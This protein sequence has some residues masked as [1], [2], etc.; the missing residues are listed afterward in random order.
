MRA[1]QHLKSQPVSP[2]TE[3]PASPPTEELCRLVPLCAADLVLLTT[4]QRRPWVGPPTEE[5]CRLMALC[6]ANLVLLTPAAAT[7]GHPP[8]RRVVQARVPSVR[9]TWSS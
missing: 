9:P 3:E 7:L 4:L 8:H 2:P 1:T 5:L 6:A